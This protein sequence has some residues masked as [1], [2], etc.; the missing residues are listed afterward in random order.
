MVDWPLSI[1]EGREGG[2]EVCA[3]PNDSVF[4]LNASCYILHGHL[5]GTFPT[6]ASILHGLGRVWSLDPSLELPRTQTWHSW[7]STILREHPALLQTFLAGA[8]W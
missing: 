1:W 3:S 4:F 5:P 8:A 7:T 2:K 6:S